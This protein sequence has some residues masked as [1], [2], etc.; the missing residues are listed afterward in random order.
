MVLLH[1]EQ[2]CFP[3]PSSC[4]DTGT[5]G[6]QGETASRTLRECQRLREQARHRHLQAWLTN[7]NS[8]S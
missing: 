2:H 5:A 1:Q 7:Q 6:S 4:S 8:Q 3:G